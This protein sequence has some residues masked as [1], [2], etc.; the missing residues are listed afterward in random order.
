MFGQKNGKIIFA[1]VVLVVVSLYAGYQLGQNTS[2]ER[3]DPLS[4]NPLLNADTQLFWEAID[5]IKSEY[6]KPDALNDQDLLYGAVSGVIHSLGDPYSSFF[7]PEDAKKFEEDIRGSF[8][9]IGAEIGIRDGRLVIIAPLKDNPASKIG[10]KPLDQILKIDDTFTNS[11]TLEEAVKM[12]RGEEGTEVVL[13]IFRDGWN[14]PRE[15]KIVRQI[16]NVPTLEWKMLDDKIAYI[17]LFSFNANAPSKFFNASASAL[18]EGARGLILDLR[19]NSGGFLDV[20]NNLAGW[21]LK[22]G[23]LIVQERFPSGE[24]TDFRAN[25]N[26]VWGNVPVVVIVNG[27]SASASEILAGALQYHLGATLVGETTFGKGTIQTIKNL[28]DGSKVK[29]SIA[30]WILPNGKTINEEGILPDVEV[31]FTEEDFEAERDPQFEKALEIIK[32]KAK[33]VKSIQTIVL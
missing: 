30:E 5:L 3:N 10:L 24:T 18:F 13:L 26:G 6:Y 32:E 9:G 27:G 29:L 19:N 31:E 20:A 25:G 7:S 12:I 15:F 21:F 23:D 2:A 16:I 22:R 8:G 4:G 28:R 14:E 11:L 33:G 1:A 17:Q